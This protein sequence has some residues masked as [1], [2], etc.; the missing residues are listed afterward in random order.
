MRDEHAIKRTARWITDR[1]D[2]I[3]LPMVALLLL[4][5]TGGGKTTA[6]LDEI[7]HGPDD[8]L[9][10]V[11]A[12]NVLA[13]K[14]LSN[15]SV[16]RLDPPGT[17]MSWSG[18][19]LVPIVLVAQSALWSGSTIDE[20]LG[21]AA[22]LTPALLGAAFVLAMRTLVWSSA[23]LIPGAPEP[24]LMAV[25]ATFTFGEF[26]AGR[27]DHH[28]LGLIAM[29]GALAL[30]LRALE[31]K[32]SIGCAL[33]A[34]ILLGAGLAVGLESAIATMVLGVGFAAAY[35]V[36]G[37]RKRADAAFALWG[38][39][40]C[41]AVALEWTLG[42]PTTL[43]EA[44][45]DEFSAPHVAGTVVAATACAGAC[46]WERIGTTT[47]RARTIAGALAACAGLA[48]IERVGGQCFGGPYAQMPETL[49]YW[50]SQ[51]REAQS[52][53]GAMANGWAAIGVITIALPIAGLTAL[54]WTRRRN[55]APLDPRWWALGGCAGAAL[56]TALWQIRGI[57]YAQA[58][59]IGAMMPLAAAAEARAEACARRMQRATMNLAIPVS[60]MLVVVLA[61]TV[62]RP[63][64]THENAPCPGPN[65]LA[66]LTDAERRGEQWLVATP[67]DAGP[68]VLL[69]TA[70]S[71]LSG[72]YHRAVRGL[73]D[74]YTLH[75]GTRAQAREIIERRAI[76]AVL[77]CKAKV[78]ITAADGVTRGFL[79]EAYLR[80]EIPGWLRPIAEDDGT[81]LYRVQ[82]VRRPPHAR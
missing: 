67:I 47:R 54:E 69:L 60:A 15:M 33:G 11:M 6:T 32:P 76:D 1:A 9:K 4:L 46:A 63:L 24:A 36:Y 38:A 78:W 80:E 29:I 40:T 34:G 39:T 28:G 51:V 8:R 43:T 71:V 5:S 81:T 64:E 35:V 72:G 25:A 50:L 18:V 7:A 3:G 74:H 66:A 79:D 57:E 49:D 17:D 75:S 44:L 2:W 13:G 41:T 73:N 61:A 37:A 53:W 12:R 27:V 30:A 20:A 21:Y 65:A 62:L 52:W 16:E 10:L 23:R 31:P 19:S 56:A 14:A 22:L 48:A 58:T 82:P 55:P 42:T 68:S 45:C 59:A 26:I 70:H 77:M